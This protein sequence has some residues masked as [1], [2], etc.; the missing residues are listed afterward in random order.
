MSF[1]DF[2]WYNLIIRKDTSQGRLWRRTISFPVVWAFLKPTQSWGLLDSKE[3]HSSSFWYDCP[4]FPQHF[5]L[6]FFHWLLF[7]SS[8][9]PRHF[10]SWKSSFDPAV[11]F[12]YYL[13][14]PHFVI[15]KIL[16]WMILICHLHFPSASPWSLPLFPV[17]LL[18]LLMIWSPSSL[19]YWNDVP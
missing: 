16:K 10:L 11:S 9:M 4:S 7:M 5:A 12:S 6:L 3:A 14:L 2:R 18:S 15:N 17:H 8:N 13:N 1:V 19:L